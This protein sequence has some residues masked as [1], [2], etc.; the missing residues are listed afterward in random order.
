MAGK[1]RK[2]K[3]RL[4]L[5][6]SP[7]E[8]QEFFASTMPR[9]SEMMGKETDR[10]SVLIAAA[11]LDV[12]LEGTLRHLMTQRSKDAHADIDRILSD[13]ALPPLGS[14]AMRIVAARALG[15]IDAQVQK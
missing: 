12:L 1:K 15:L 5:P 11:F 9:F 8:I 6:A 14:F 7:E 3:E 4:R 10:G 2:R 13:G